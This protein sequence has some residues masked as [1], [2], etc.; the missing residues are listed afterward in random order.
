MVWLELEVAL[1]TRLAASAMSCL[2]GIQDKSARTSL[3]LPASVANNKLH[4]SRLMCDECLDVPPT[5]SHGTPSVVLA[6]DCPILEHKPA[7]LLHR[8]HHHLAKIFL[9][10]HL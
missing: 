8:E 10:S 9:S 5:S 7:S 3:R 2:V 6:S 1:A 4:S